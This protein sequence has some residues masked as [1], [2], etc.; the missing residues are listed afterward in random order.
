MTREGARSIEVGM[1]LG[2]GGGPGNDSL[3]RT[4][5]GTA[6]GTTKGGPAAVQFLPHSIQ[7]SSS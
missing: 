3:I 6:T 1:T 2:P 4:V 7:C 5:L